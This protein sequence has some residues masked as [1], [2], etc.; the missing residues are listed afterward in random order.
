MGNTSEDSTIQGLVSPDALKVAPSRA[1]LVTYSTILDELTERKI[2]RTRDAPAGQL[3]ERLAEVAFSGELAPNAEKSW[4]C[5][6]SDGR[7]C[8]SSV[9]CWVPQSPT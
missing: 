9:E 6:L 8:K 7:P 4:D 5:R 2:V 3:A 1:L